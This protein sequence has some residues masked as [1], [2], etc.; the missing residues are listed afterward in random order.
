MVGL[1]RPDPGIGGNRDHETRPF[2]RQASASPSKLPST[3]SRAHQLT[4]LPLAEAGIDKK[5]FS[6]AQKANLENALEHAITVIGKQ[7]YGD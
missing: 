4:I 7:L 2:S 5:Q 3:V 1:K 6:R